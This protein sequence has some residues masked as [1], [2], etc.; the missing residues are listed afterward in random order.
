MA[1]INVYRFKKFEVSLGKYITSQAYATIETI[2]S[3]AG[4]VSIKQDF[5]EIEESILDGNNLYTP[6]QA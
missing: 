3:I 4:C 6:N 1:L 5:I 2:E